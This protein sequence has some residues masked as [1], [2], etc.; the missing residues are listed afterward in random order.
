L[1]QFR[2]FLD[3]LGLVDLIGDFSDDQTFALGPFDVN[4]TTT[5]VAADDDRVFIGGDF[6][7]YGGASARNIAKFDIES[8]V[9]VVA[10][11]ADA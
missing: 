10:L 9:G 5:C 3:Q 11:H 4:G 2:D 7:Y 8:G 1:N 6:G